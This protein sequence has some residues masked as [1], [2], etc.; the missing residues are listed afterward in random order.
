MQVI[1]RFETVLDDYE[2]LEMS[3]KGFCLG[4]T[5]ELPDGSRRQLSFY[6]PGRLTQDLELDI[7]GGNAPCLAFPGLIVVPEVRPEWMQRAVDYLA[8]QGFFEHLR[9]LPADPEAN[10]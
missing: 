8:S 4:V 10:P 6:D 7:A 2:I 9:P 3:S 1:L 5:A